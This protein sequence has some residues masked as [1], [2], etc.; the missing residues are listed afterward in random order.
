MV[1]I[2]T[3]RILVFT[4]IWDISLTNRETQLLKKILASTIKAQIHLDKNLIV[5]KNCQKS[6]RIAHDTPIP[7]FSI[8]IYIWNLHNKFL[9]TL[10]T[11]CQINLTL[12]TQVMASVLEALFSIKRINHVTA[13]RLNTIVF[14]K[15]FSM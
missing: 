4:T 3:S 6:T 11:K 15:S 7:L 2:K 8:D 10:N 13:D 12:N 5:K 1:V 9:I 14:N